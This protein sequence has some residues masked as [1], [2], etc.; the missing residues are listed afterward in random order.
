VIGPGGR[1]RGRTG[2]TRAVAC[3]ALAVAAGLLVA[4]ACRET[5]LTASSE[6]EANRAAA[7]LE[8]HGVPARVESTR[9]GR[10]TSFA[11]AV[12]ADDAPHARSL[13]AAYGLPRPP[14]TTALSQGAGLV[15]SPLEE[16]ARVAAAVARD[17]EQS[18]EAVDGIV[19]ARVHLAFALDEDPLFGSEPR[20]RPPCASALVRHAGESSPLPAD[21]VRRLVAGAVDGLSP[22]NVEVVFDPIEVP[23]DG[24]EG[25][26]TV[27]PFDV[28]SG[29]RGP[30]LAALVGLLATCAALG[31]LLVVSRIARRRAARGKGPDRPTDSAGSAE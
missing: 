2:E 6:A 8:R 17:V 28:R 18:L 30:L 31:G 22:G 9:Q 1:D 20:V 23:A 3:L 26:T 19:E 12:S 27:G 29:S 11:L 13:L 14:R 25:W 15:P 16:R 5:V 4:T 21:D 10:S 24:S 7:L